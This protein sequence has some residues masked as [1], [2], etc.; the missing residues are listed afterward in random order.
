[1]AFCVKCMNS[2]SVEIVNSRSLFQCDECE[3]RKEIPGI[4]RTKTKLTPKEEMIENA[5]PQEFPERYA[6]CPEC[7]ST[8]A[9][10]YQMQ[11]R[12]ADEPMTIFNTCT[13]CKHTWR[14]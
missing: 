2:L 4:Y 10:Y 6:L 1:M 5:E 13:K 9:N 3:Y 8:T 11:T 14:E 7:F 12:S